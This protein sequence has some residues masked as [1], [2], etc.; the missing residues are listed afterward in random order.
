MSEVELFVELYRLIKWTLVGGLILI[1]FWGFWKFLDPEESEEQKFCDACKPAA[2]HHYGTVTPIP[3]DYNDRWFEYNDVPYSGV[4][5]P[6]WDDFTRQC[7][8]YESMQRKRL[9]SA[10]T[11]EILTVAA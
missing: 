4:R 1:A 10:D 9:T 3:T 8:R 2:K 6:D 11:F 5:M 7:L